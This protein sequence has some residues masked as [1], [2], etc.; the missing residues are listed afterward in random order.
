MARPTVEQLEKINR[1]ARTPLNADEVEVFENLMIDTLP[2]KSHGIV[3]SEKILQK[4][5]EDIKN[6]V[7]QMLSHLTDLLPVGKVYDGR[8][9]EEEVDGQVVKTLY[10]EFYIP[11]G[12]KVTGY[13]IITDDLI[14]MINKGILTDTSIGFYATEIKCNICGND[15][16]NVFACQHVPNKTYEVDGKEVTCYGIVDGDGEL[17]ENSLVYSGACERAMVLSKTG[18]TDIKVQRKEGIK[19]EDIKNIPLDA[20]MMFKFSKNN[21]IEVY[22]DKLMDEDEIG[23]DDPIEIDNSADS[24]DNTPWGQV[25][26]ENLRKRIMRARNYKTLV[27]EA[28]LVVEDGYE[29]APSQHLKYPHHVIKNGKLVV[30]KTGVRAAKIRLMQNDPHNESALRH[31]RKHERELGMGEEESTVTIDELKELIEILTNEINECLERERI[32]QDMIKKLEFEKEQLSIYEAKY[33]QKL[34]NECKVLGINDVAKED[35][36]EL[37]IEELEKKVDSLRRNFIES[38]TKQKQEKVIEDKP[39]VE[40]VEEKELSEE[41]KF[42]MMSYEE[43]QNFIIKKAKEFAENNKV[44]MREALKEMYKKFGNLIKSE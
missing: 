26:L 33:R 2:V 29:T 43:Q 23:K 12:M 25:D 20:K 31:L 36:D 1:F 9:V 44:S 35:L 28:Y 38:L 17:L 16:R 4:F 7:P 5:L 37:S 22:V 3:I 10:G 11:K 41:E 13:N 30:S 32:Y 21:G 42:S 18:D 14:E 39:E 34:I 24:A 40:V 6:G 8:L 15:I 19:V 27:K